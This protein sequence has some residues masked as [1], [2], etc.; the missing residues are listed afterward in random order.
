MKSHQ[1]KSLSA[2]RNS[3]MPKSLKRAAPEDQVKAFRR[4]AR[5]LGCDGNEERFKNALRTIAKQKAKSSKDKG[6]RP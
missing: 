2:A 6:T 4:A 1:T 3:E 5:E